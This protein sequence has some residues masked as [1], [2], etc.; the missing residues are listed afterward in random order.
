MTVKAT[1]DGKTAFVTYLKKKPTASVWLG[2][3]AGAV[4]CSPEEATV[5]KIEF[6]EEGRTIYCSPDV[7]HG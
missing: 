7:A 4:E 5:M 3:R 6:R 1:V 2:W